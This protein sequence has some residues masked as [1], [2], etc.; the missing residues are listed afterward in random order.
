MCHHPSDVDAAE[1]YE[2]QWLSK[3]GALGRLPIKLYQQRP[4]EVDVP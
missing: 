2:V 4:A 1:V 3:T